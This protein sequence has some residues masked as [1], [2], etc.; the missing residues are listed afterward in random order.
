[1]IW[2]ITSPARL[3]CTM[4]PTRRS[5]SA[6]RSKLCSVASLT[7]VPP[8]S[9][10]SRIA[11]G[12]S[13]PVRP[14]LTPI[15]K[16]RVT[17]MSGANFR[18]I[19]Q[20]GSRPAHHAQVFLEGQRVDFDHT[21]VDREV[22]RRADLVLDLV[23]PGGDLGERAAAGAVWRDR[24]P[25]A[26]QRLQE[27]PLGVERQPRPRGGRSFA[28]GGFIGGRIPDRDRV[29]EEAQGAIRGDGR[30]ELPERAGRGV[31]RIGEDR[32]A[33]RGARLV[34]LLEAVE[35]HVDLASHLDEMRGRRSTAAKA[36]R[37]VADR[38]EVGRDIL[39]DAAI[40]AGRAGDEDAIPVR[41]ADGRAV[42]LELGGEPGAMDG[43]ARQAF[44]ALIPGGDFVVGEGVA[45]RQHRH[46][47]GVLRQLAL[48]RRAD[49]LRRRV[50]RAERRVLGLER[51]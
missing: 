13:A 39:A 19:A 18:A 27:I 31:A 2:G 34:H 40:A 14:T 42:D 50:G 23:G 3:T 15:P 22:Q 1:M 24:D 17:A 45:E 30:I 38:A 33:V 35:R 36:E 12:L 6:T 32:I 25:P 20:R 9:T 29:A 48:G 49:A 28:R 44:D 51:L 43:I 26:G 4:S 7:V 21:A 16:R 41:Q 11:Y 10:G 37:D 5:F 47:V 8:I 46:E